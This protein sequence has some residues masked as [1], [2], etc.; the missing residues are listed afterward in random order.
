MGLSASARKDIGRECQFNISAGA[1]LS[2]PYSEDGPS[3]KKVSEVGTAGCFFNQF[4]FLPRQFYG[5]TAAD[6]GRLNYLGIYYFSTK[7]VR[8]RMRIDSPRLDSRY[9]MQS[10]GLDHITKLNL[11]FLPSSFLILPNRTRLKAFLIMHPSLIPIQILWMLGLPYLCQLA[12][13]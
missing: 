9:Y 11:T 12:E 7:F 2:V 1:E 4:G 8:A 3:Y 13:I 10:Y 6:D 5:K